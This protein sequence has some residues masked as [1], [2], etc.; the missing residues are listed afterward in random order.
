MK[1]FE[2]MTPIELKVLINKT[3]ENHT[4]VKE[5]IVEL[6]YEV[7]SLEVQINDYLDKMHFIEGR[8]VEMMGVLMSKQGKPIVEEK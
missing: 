6:T 8:Y 7:D 3:E 1:K 5:K 4:L 2:E